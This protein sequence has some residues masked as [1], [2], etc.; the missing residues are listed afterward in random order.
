MGAAH[1][2]EQGAMGKGR[3]H[4]QCECCFVVVDFNAKPLSAM[5]STGCSEE[6]TMRAASIGLLENRRQQL[7]CDFSVRCRHAVSVCDS[8]VH[9]IHTRTNLQRAN[10]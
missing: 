9:L 6:E 2:R 4:P 3:F 10:L 1:E 7:V 5:R 8:A